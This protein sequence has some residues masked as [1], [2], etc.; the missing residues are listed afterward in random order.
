MTTDLRKEK[1]QEVVA[2]GEM[3]KPDAGGSGGDCG[4][5][6]PYYDV[7]MS[8]SLQ[9]NFSRVL[10]GDYV[11]IDDMELP[12]PGSYEETHPYLITAIDLSS[13]P[14]SYTMLAITDALLNSPSGA[15]TADTSPCLLCTEGF[16]VDYDIVSCASDIVFCTIKRDVYSPFIMFVD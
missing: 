3:T 1:Y 12:V 13:S 14:A 2:T 5:T 8:V 6:G 4:G 15:T 10:V 11:Y 16:E 9:E 7:A